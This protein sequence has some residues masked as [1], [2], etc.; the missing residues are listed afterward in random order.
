MVLFQ[1]EEFYFFLNLSGLV[2]RRQDSRAFLY[3]VGFFFF[4][5]QFLPALLCSMPVIV[6]HLEA[7]AGTGRPLSE[8]VS[9]WI[10]RG[11]VLWCLSLLRAFCGSSPGGCPTGAGGVE[12]FHPATPY[13]TSCCKL[14]AIRLCLPLQRLGTNLPF[15]AF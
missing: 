1:N 7:G 3:F 4:P 5:L 11:A 14:Q 8:S 15:F 12:D 9:C 10:P 6:E 13:Y 2:E